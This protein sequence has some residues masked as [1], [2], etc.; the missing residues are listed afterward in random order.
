MLP[1][2]LLK[3]IFA[4]PVFFEYSIFSALANPPP[5]ALE[6]GVMPYNFR[7]PLKTLDKT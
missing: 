3:A 6:L 5:A 2:I 1:R 4:M 7:E